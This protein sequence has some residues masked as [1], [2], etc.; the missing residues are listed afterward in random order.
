VLPPQFSKRAKGSIFH[1]ST[2]TPGVWFIGK[3]MNSLRP[4]GHSTS[5]GL[6][7]R[8][9]SKEKSGILAPSVVFKDLCSALTLKKYNKGFLNTRSFFLPKIWRPFFSIRLAVVGDCSRRLFEGA[10]PSYEG[11]KGAVWA[12]KGHF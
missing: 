1:H 6:C 4:K 8:L 9:T 10:P 7:R 2:A 11:K 12:K 3:N 5:A